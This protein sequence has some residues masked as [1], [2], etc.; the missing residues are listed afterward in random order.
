M[1][2]SFRIIRGGRG[3]RRGFVWG[4]GLGR[5]VIRRGG[6]RGWGGVGRVVCWWCGEV[7]GVGLWCGGVGGPVSE[8]L[9]E[10]F[11]FGDGERE[12]G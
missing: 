11:G 7:G 5:G 2:A 8:M 12:W 6:G 10:R 4:V 3:G 1:W 9:F